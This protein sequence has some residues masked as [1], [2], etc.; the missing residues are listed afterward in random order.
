MTNIGDA[1]RLRRSRVARERIIARAVSAEG[2]T[3]VKEKV[4]PRSLAF[5][6]RSNRVASDL[7]TAIRRVDVGGSK[8][9]ALPVRQLHIPICVSSRIAERTRSAG[10]KRSR[11]TRTLSVVAQ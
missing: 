10:T 3:A 4:A 8:R 9:L 1:D 2:E 11:I 7:T 5:A 6:A